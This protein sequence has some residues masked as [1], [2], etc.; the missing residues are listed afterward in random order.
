MAS[1]AA[2]PVVVSRLL[3]PDDAN[4]AGNVHGGT[5]LKLMEEAGH[6]A[7][8]RLMSPSAANK[9]SNG[10]CLA[11]LVRFENMAFHKPIFVGEVASCMCEIIFTSKQSILVEVV[12][13][14]EDIS[15]G[16]TSVTNT[17]WLWYVPM[18]PSTCDASNKIWKVVDALPMAMP[19]GDNIAMRKYEKAKSIYETRKNSS[20]S[21]ATE[22]DS[23]HT[24][25]IASDSEFDIF[26]SLYTTPTEGRTP[27]E[28]EQVLCQMVLPGDCSKEKIAFGGFIMKLMDNAAGCSAWRYCRTNV[29]TVA[30]S[31]MDFVSWIRL[32]DLCTIRS[33]V[34]FASSKSL[35][36]EVIASV[37][38]ATSEK[39]GDTLVARG[40][41]TFVSLCVDGKVLSVP[42][43][44]LENDE[45]FK[46]A[47][48]G[49]QR[50]EA[51]KKARMEGSK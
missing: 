27:T 36:I 39:E 6:I 5:T 26:K 33:K 3:L 46:N 31:D 19:E 48:L 50:Y 9:E 44:K 38:S 28:S 21:A 2:S 45:D 35:E 11:A 51:A 22:K 24:Y 25:T 30:I 42:K 18:V 10:N 16:N 32:G 20:Q 43:L 34:V 49:E 29:V 41:F 40:L 1:K 12:V 17:G 47:Y 14:G 23:R 7:A 4:P 37:V 13:R 15:K 8:T